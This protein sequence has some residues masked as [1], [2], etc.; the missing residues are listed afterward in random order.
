[1]PINDLTRFTRLLMVLFLWGGMMS[2]QTSHASCGMSDIQEIHTI[3]SLSALLRSQKNTPFEP[4]DQARY[5]HAKVLFSELFNTTNS[6]AKA[7]TKH[8]L[9]DEL[10]TLIALAGFC[11]QWLTIKHQ[12]H[13][14]HLLL[15]MEREHIA[16]GQGAYLFA[17]N[18]PLKFVIQAPHQYFDLST[19]RLALQIFLEQ[20]LRAVALNTV[21]RH[22]TDQSDLAHQTQSLFS[23]FAEALPYQNSER[24]L[25]QIHGFSKKHRRTAAGKEADIIISNGSRSPSPFLVNAKARMSQN[26]AFKTYLYGIDIDE[27]GGTQNSSLASLANINQQHHFI[28]L[29]L[30]SA[31]RKHLKSSHAQRSALWSSW[32]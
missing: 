10:N 7:L 31:T 12:K 2:I 1:M 22:Q 18:N 23:A 13:D 6:N 32:P 20:N 19:G 26:T 30:S 9:P 27:L 15:L 16:S 21:H 25:L 11:Q 5:Q 29:E 17:M 8:S 14:H 3:K 28:H 24:Y 4:I